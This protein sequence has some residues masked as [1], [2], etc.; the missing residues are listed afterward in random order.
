MAG[1]VSCRR[2]PHKGAVSAAEHRLGQTADADLDGEQAA[3]HWRGC[4]LARLRLGGGTGDIKRV[5]VL[6]A[7]ADAGRIGH[8]HLEGAVNAA[9]GSVTCDP[10]AAVL[11]VPQKSLNL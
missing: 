1:S 3:L 2:G 9:V 4:A 11:R 7:E 6:A 10:M 8:R 5:E